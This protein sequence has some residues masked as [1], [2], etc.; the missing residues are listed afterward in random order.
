MTF[1]TDHPNV[2]LTSNY[3][4]NIVDMATQKYDLSIRIGRLHET[5]FM[6]KKLGEIQHILVATPDFLKRYDDISH[7]EMLSNL[8][9]NSR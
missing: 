6:R 9:C 4:D 7:P 3:S 2:D 1:A 5:S 8:P